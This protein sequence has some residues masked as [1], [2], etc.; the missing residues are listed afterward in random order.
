MKQSID[1]FL[2]YVL[3]NKYDSGENYLPYPWYFCIFKA[4]LFLFFEV[5]VM[6]SEFKILLELSAKCIKSLI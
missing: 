5:P 4:D 3:A 2:C 6:I 1:V